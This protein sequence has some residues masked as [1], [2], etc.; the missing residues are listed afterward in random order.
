MPECKSLTVGLAVACRHGCFFEVK[1]DGE[2][3]WCYLNPVI[4]TAED[5]QQLKVV[6]QGSVMATYDDNDGDDEE[7]EDED[8]AKEEE[9]EELSATDAAVRSL[10]TAIQI[11]EEAHA[12]SIEKLNAAIS[13]LEAAAAP[14]DP[15]EKRL[16]YCDG[17]AGS[18]GNSTFRAERLALDHPALVGR[19][20]TPKGALE[21]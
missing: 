19:D 8:E 11:E 12:Q 7:D 18:W 17:T 14:P 6:P 4:G 9:E 1:R 13:D 10:L 20:L 16:P 5:S 2:L 3:C 15:E 21:G